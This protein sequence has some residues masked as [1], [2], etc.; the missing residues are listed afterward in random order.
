MFLRYGIPPFYIDVERKEEYYN[1]LEIA[2]K[3]KNFNALYEYIF[4]ALIRAHVELAAY[5]ATI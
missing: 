3:E 1:A 4:R 2:D 5:P